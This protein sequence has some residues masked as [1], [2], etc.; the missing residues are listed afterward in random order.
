MA[1]IKVDSSNIRTL[2]Y[3]SKSRRLIVGFK[4]SGE[5]SYFGVPEKVFKAFVESE[6]KGSFFHKVIRNNYKYEKTV[7]KAKEIMDI[8]NKFLDEA[9]YKGQRRVTEIKRVDGKWEVVMLKPHAMFII[10]DEGKI[11]DTYG[12]FRKEEKKHE[13]RNVKS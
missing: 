12:V 6:S 8:V 2:D 9:N 5:Y 10:T 4:P 3:D 1:K 11:I 7:D 13:D